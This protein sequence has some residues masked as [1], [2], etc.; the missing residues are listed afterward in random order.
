MNIIL[1]IATLSQTIFSFGTILLH[2]ISV[3]FTFII[4][5]TITLSGE[6]YQFYG[7]EETGHIESRGTKEFLP[8]SISPPYY[9]HEFAKEQDI[10]ALGITLYTLATNKLPT[11]NIESM[12]LHEREDFL[13][14]LHTN[15]DWSSRAISTDYKV[16]VQRLLTPVCTIPPL[17]HF[18]LFILSLLGLFTTSNE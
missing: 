13:W 6:F 4:H 11:Q 9:S 1:F 2:F 14:N 17:P 12:T 18:S 3:L 8:P 15:L 10:W 16:L 7:T 5:L